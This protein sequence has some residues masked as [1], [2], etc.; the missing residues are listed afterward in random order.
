MRQL[1]VFAS[2][3]DGLVVLF[4]SVAIGQSNYIGVGLVRHSVGHRSN[5]HNSLPT[6]AAS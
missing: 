6:T 3:P 1:H 4:T 2:N 5:K